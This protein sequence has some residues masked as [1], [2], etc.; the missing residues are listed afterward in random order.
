MN[1]KF[2]LIYVHVSGDPMKTLSLATVA[3]ALLAALFFMNRPPS[4]KPAAHSPK[5]LLDGFYSFSSQEYVEAQLRAKTLGWK[6]SDQTFAGG[7]GGA[8]LVQMVFEVEGYIHLGVTG[9]LF[10]SFV[11]DRLWSA[12][13][14]PNRLND[15]TDALKNRLSLD[16]LE[17][18]HIL[19]NGVH[20]VFLNNQRDEFQVRWFDEDLSDELV[21]AGF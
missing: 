15:Y 2:R 9:S 11:N 17:N 18:S 13:F 6:Q 4:F 3:I 12:T 16:I 21:T 7:G 10:L 20:T 1:A 19:K 5:I 8:L 14:R